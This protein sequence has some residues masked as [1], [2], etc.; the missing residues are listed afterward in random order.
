[1]TETHAQRRARVDG[2]AARTGK[3]H[4]YVD[5]GTPKT[6]PGW[7]FAG[8]VRAMSPRPREEVNATWDYLDHLD[9]VYGWDND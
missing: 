5:P 6:G 4:F 7:L 2:L 3:P 8:S 1:M 9:T